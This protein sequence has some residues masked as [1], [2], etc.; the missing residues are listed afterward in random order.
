MTQESL[1]REVGVSLRVVQSWCG[2]SVAQPR[3][4][5]TVAVAR[6]LGFDPSWFF[7]DRPARSEAA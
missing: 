3:W 7:V 1:A 5:H 6:I 2:G 4:A